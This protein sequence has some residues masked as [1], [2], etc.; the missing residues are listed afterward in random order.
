VKMKPGAKRLSG[1]STKKNV[2]TNTMDEDS[3]VAALA[4]QSA[5]RLN[6]SLKEDAANKLEILY[7]KITT[8]PEKYLNVVTGRYSTGLFGGVSSFPVTVTN[9]SGISI[10]LLE[11]SI[12]YVQNNEKIF[13]TKLFLLMTLNQ[14][15]HSA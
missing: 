2:K 12:D 5:K 10:A 15:K 11:V 4:I 3:I 8:E 9:N 13:K 7:Q 14:V 6:D 1:I